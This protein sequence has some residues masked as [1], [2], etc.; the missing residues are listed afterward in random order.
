MILCLLLIILRRFMD[1]RFNT[2]K[3]GILGGGQLG[4][5]LLQK[6]VDFSLKIRILDPDPEAPCQ[7]LA[8]EFIVGD[9]SDYNT[10]YKFGKECDLLTIE[11]EHVN[12]EALE[13]LEKEGVLVYPQPNVIR[14]VQDKGEQKLFFKKHG[15][16]TADFSITKDKNEISQIPEMLPAM[17]KLRKG[18]YDGKGVFRI[19]STADIENSF[20]APSVIEKLIPFEKEIS[21]IVARKINGETLCFPPVEMDFNT[22]ANLVEFLY[23]PAELDK[24]TET[25]AYEIASRLA[26]TLSIVGILAVEMF[27]TPEKEL[28]VNEIAPRPH[29]SGHHTIEAN[30]TSQY[31]QLL[32]AILD[33]PLGKTDVTCNAVMI[34]LLGEKNYEGRAVYQSFEEAM[35]MEGVYIHLYGKKNTRPYRKM[36][37]VTVTGKN[38]EDAKRK[39]LTIK[40]ILKVTAE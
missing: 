21:V 32:R 27:L 1:K 10:V 7:H 18:G 2:L 33:L 4:R 24:K 5:M 28:L 6:A 17:Q 26:N 12:V 34:N 23:S 19:S 22:E 37:H 11:I 3:I 39:A 9:F 16:P 30:M 15:I 36:G 8:E 29:N 38:K 35:K 25:K 31:E 14:I 20:D 13:K 40:N